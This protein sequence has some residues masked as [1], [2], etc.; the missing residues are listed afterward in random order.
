MPP[1]L[2]T[3][4][5][6]AFLC[7]CAPT[8][9]ANPVSAITPLADESTLSSAA[10]GVWKSDGYG[11][12]L[13][14]TVTPK[15]YNVAGDFCQV[16]TDGQE[17][18][19]QYFDQLRFNR[20]KSDLLLSSVSEPYEIKFDRLERLPVTCRVP[21]AT[22]ALAIFDAF[23]QTYAQHYAFFDTHGVDW[24]AATAQ[25]RAKLTPNSSEQALVETFIGLLSGLK[26][27][28]VSIS[29]TVDGEEGQF[30]AYPGR[31]NEAIQHAHSGEGSAM[32]AFGTQYLRRDIEE[33]ILGGQGIDFPN[34]RIKYGLTD[35]DIGYMAVMA[36]GGFADGRNAS[37]EE[38]LAA[39]EPALDQAMAF[40]NQN[41]VK[42]I[43]VD[44]S[45]NSGGYDYIS[46]TIAARF[47]KERA[48]AYSKQAYNTQSQT[49][50]RIYI[51]P[52]A[53][54][55]YVG[56]VYVLTSDMTVSAGEVLTMSLRALPNATHAGEA[57]R[58]AFS[59][60]LYKYLPNGWEVTLSNEVYADHAGQ[61]WEG[62][63]IEPQ[64][65]IQVFDPAN[66][67]TGHADAVMKLISVIRAQ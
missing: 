37:P 27:G 33:T 6:V 3:L 63:G 39:L 25:A 15:V 40:F 43:I 38:E 57:T 44:L 11:F 45:V 48:F 56:P 29:A 8:T 49:P 30:I 14:S 16:I 2:R 32:A 54:A 18:P 35:G 59:D 58:G 53:G 41:S 55:R 61:E 17:S 10:P 67:F 34:E 21:Q 52:S 50:T 24:P 51:E 26:D 1:K 13:D 47:A 19:L 20:D 65:P 60:V 66:P 4:I 64:L 22:D 5:P 62:K 7:S 31:T 23:A 9:I 42:A 12:I 28:H 46:R 36:E